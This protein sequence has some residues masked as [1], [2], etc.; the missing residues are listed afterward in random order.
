MALRVSFIVEWANTRLNGVPRAWTLLEILGKQWQQLSQHDYP[1]SLPI[2]AVG[3]LSQV[4]PRAELIVV[5]GDPAT[6]GLASEIRR[7]VPESIDVHVVVS[8]GLEYYPLKNQGAQKA[9]G[10]FLVFV[11]SDVWPDD[12]WMA[13][14][15]GSFGR[16]DIDV[17]C[18]QTYVAPT[19]VYSRAFAL[20]WTYLPKDESGKLFKPSKF[21]ANSIAFRS[22]V[23]RRTGFPPAG[24]RT[25]GSATLI[26]DELAR[27]G[28]PVWANHRASVDHPPPADFRHL[29]VRAIAHGRDQ[30][31]KLSE[32]RHL[33]GLVRS[34]RIAAQ[35][36]G[37]GL[38]RICRYADRVGLRPWQIPSAMAICSSYY[39]FFALGGW[40]T[41]VNPQAMGTRF[42]V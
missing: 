31:M 1:D 12:G 17:V 30:Y 3:L 21:Y 23:F 10:D 5:S 13:H 32:T 9:T 29:A 38:Y 15:I 16:S 7:R 34:Q 27:I 28:I 14:L 18:G 22:E 8:E 33:A 40:M 6:A 25:R 19:D 39:A 41:H 2:E 35:R 42:R 4:D 36:W 24:R 20:G 11:D 26:K 37:Q